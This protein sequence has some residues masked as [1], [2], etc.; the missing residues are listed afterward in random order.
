MSL[1]DKA[2]ASVG[3][4][5]AKV[6]TNLDKQ[7]F[8]EGEQV[9]G[10]IS[11]LGGRTEQKASKVS[12]ILLTYINI[13][14]EDYEIRKPIEIFR[15]DVAQ[16]V[17]IKPNVE[18]KIPFS[19][20]LPNDT[21]ISFN[22]DIVW[23]ETNLDIKKAIDP[24]DTTYIHVMPHPYIQQALNVLQNDLKFILTKYESV[25]VPNNGIHLPVI[26]V[27]DFNP[28][29][30]LAG[31]LNELKIVFFVDDLRGLEI[32]LEILNKPPI[33]EVND[34]NGSSINDKIQLFIPKDEFSKKSSYL[35]DLLLKN[36]KS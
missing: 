3:L 10:F 34:N 12:L 26:Q 32:I 5:S 14:E 28:P 31:N 1:L 27:F 8:F 2:M 15:F 21:P 18:I 6:K 24:S 29:S 17:L 7:K 25:Y 9:T 35:A 16:N 13:E 19:F 4:G 33:S 22:K 36:I 11:V 23:I 30:H 20:A